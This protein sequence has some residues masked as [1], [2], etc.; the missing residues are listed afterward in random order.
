MTT[1]SDIR[2]ISTRLHSHV[3]EW[4]DLY[5]QNELLFL[6]DDLQ[7]LHGELDKRG[8]PNT[9]AQGY[10]LDLRQRCRLLCAKQKPLQGQP[11][12]DSKTIRSSLL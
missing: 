11:D 2:Q 9:D 12:H 7:M 6:L 8:V 3:L 10:E 1:L 4:S 5:L